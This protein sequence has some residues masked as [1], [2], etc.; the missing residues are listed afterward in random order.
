MA[1]PI[2][3]VPRP[4]SALRR[5]SIIQLAGTF[6]DDRTGVASAL[7]GLLKNAPDDSL[8]LWGRVGVGANRGKLHIGPH[9]DPLP[10]GEGPFQ[11]AAHGDHKSFAT[12][13]RQMQTL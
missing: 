2:A 1:A 3:A 11:Q 7:N 10:A 12:P 8:H 13:N 9:P 4:A 5:L 6:D